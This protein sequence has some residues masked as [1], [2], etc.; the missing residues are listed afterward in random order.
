M[1]YAL[2][3]EDGEPGGPFVVT[4]LTK[5]VKATLT[6]CVLLPR[7][8]ITC[9][10]LWVGCRWLL[11]TNNFDD[12]ILNSVALEF[13]LCLKDVLFVA[14]VPRRSTLDLAE[15]KVRPA[16]KKEP[17]SWFALVG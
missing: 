15:T 16:L 5:S 12:L 4:G 7:L 8:C 10:L 17:E 9:F 11:A 6:I 14:M 2:E 3:D 1:K 13:I